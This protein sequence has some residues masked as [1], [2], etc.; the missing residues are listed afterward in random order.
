MRLMNV[1]SQ[2]KSLKL[3]FLFLNKEI[4]ENEMQKEYLKSLTLLE[5]LEFKKMLSEPEDNMTAI[6]TINPGAGGTESQDW[7]EMLMRMYIMWAEKR[8]SK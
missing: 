4:L 8:I 1:M 6:L 2:L 5:D 3:C 7:A